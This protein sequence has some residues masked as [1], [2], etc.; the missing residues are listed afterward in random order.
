MEGGNT[1]M[2]PQYGP[3]RRDSLEPLSTSKT[4]SFRPIAPINA[5]SAAIA[6][7][8]R[9]AAQ[10]RAAY[11]DFWPET[12]RALIVHSARWNEAMLGGI[13]PFQA[14]SRENRMRFVQMLRTY[15]FGEPDEIRAR[16]SSEQAVTL[17]RED[18]ITPYR[19][20]AGGASL[21][22]CHI[23][24][25]QLPTEKLREYPDATC[26]M[27]VTI[28][29]FT[30]PNPSSQNRIGGSRYRYAGGLLRFL[31]RHKDE[32]IEEFEGRYSS[33]ASEENDDD[34][35]SEDETRSLTDRS[36]AFPHL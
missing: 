12:I 13:D 24:H 31:V 2:H 16:F 35:S 5:T 33:D 18:S 29:Y 10:L 21:N 14:F 30:A 3:E 28:S 9:L 26:I 6:L 22:K 34:T 27:R 7:A 20:S 17:V 15:G 32:S 1:G 25:L 8:G 4:V 11:P 36:W 19:G 23:H